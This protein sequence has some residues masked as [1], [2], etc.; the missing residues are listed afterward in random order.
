MSAARSLS[1]WQV[2]LH[3]VNHK[4]RKLLLTPKL[5]TCR[6]RPACLLH[7]KDMVERAVVDLVVASEGSTKKGSV[8]PR[9]VAVK[10]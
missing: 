8:G 6:Y 9:I 4:L 7:S 1:L 3:F 2:S 10:T 5:T